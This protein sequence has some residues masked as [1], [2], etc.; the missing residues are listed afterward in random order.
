MKNKIETI[1]TINFG[2]VVVAGSIFA[3][4]IMEFKLSQI[5]HASYEAIVLV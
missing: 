2:Q 1:N 5:N 3:K 4:I